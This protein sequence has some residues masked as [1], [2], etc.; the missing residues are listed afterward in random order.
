M[1]ISAY[2]L[3]YLKQHRIAKVAGFGE[4]SLENSKA[5]INPE[6]GSI[7]PP[8]SKI[9]FVSDYQMTSDDLLKFISSQKNISIEQAASELQVQTDF[10][11]KKL[12]ADQ[13]LEI[14][15][16]GEIHINDNETHFIGKRLEIEQPDFY[17]LEEIKFSDIKNSSQASAAPVSTSN[18][19]YKFNKSI[20]WIFLVGVPVA[21]ILY[22]AFS[23]RD[24][25]FGKKS[26]DDVSI[27]T[28]TLRIE[29]KN[30]ATDSAATAAGK[31]SLQS[32]PQ[33]TLTNQQN[34]S[35]KSQWKK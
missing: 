28:K 32:I 4:F 16:F 10:W 35:T 30:P 7:L 24:Y 5:M 9:A 29:E 11:K 15:H 27:K 34:T 20:L 13:F 18:N 14:P 3:E 12:Q 33:D 23:Q 22:L 2:I 25:L 17:G 1:N 19:D 21:G 26:F 8:S 6:N 31:D